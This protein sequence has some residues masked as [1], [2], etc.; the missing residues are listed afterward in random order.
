MFLNSRFLSVRSS[1]TLTQAPCFQPC[2]CNHRAPTNSPQASFCSLRTFCSNHLRLLS[3]TCIRPKYTRA[4]SFAVSSA[5]Y[6]LPFFLHGGNSS[7]IYNLT[8]KITLRSNFI[9]FHSI[10]KFSFKAL[11]VLQLDTSCPQFFLFRP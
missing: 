7:F 1:R 11:L 9:W 8:L 3:M 4:F 2:C 6:G 5:W 10:N